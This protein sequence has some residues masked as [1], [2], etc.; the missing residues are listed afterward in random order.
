MYVEHCNSLTD[1]N[2]IISLHKIE[3]IARN[4]EFF[5]TLF[6]FDVSIVTYVELHKSIKGHTGRHFC[7]YI[8]IDI[9]C[10][11][12]MIQAKMDAL[13]LIKKLN[14][15]YGIDPDQLYIY[16]SGGKGFHV[17]IPGQLF[18]P[19]EPS[20]NMG[21]KIK[22]V[23]SALAGEI[24]SVDLKIY[25]NHRI[26]RVENSKHKKGFYKIQLS[27]DELN[28]WTVNKILKVAKK[29]R[30]FFRVYTNQELSINEKLS[31][32]ILST[33]NAEVQVKKDL[34]QDSFF[35][36]P[37]KGN[38]NNQ[39]HKQA[40]SLYMY[41]DLSDTNIFSLVSSINSLSSEPLLEQELKNI[42]HSASS[43]RNVSTNNSP[44]TFSVVKDFTEEFKKSLREESSKISLCFESLDIE[45]KGKLRSKMGVILG[46]GGSKKSIYAQ[47]VTYGNI[48]MGHRVVYS[49]MEMGGIELVKRFY[50]IH[51]QGERDLASEE[52]ENIAKKD[53]NEAEIRIDQNFSEWFSD[54]LIISNGTAMTADNYESLLIDLNNTIG[55]VD[56]LIVDGLSMMGGKGDELEKANRNTQELKELSI[57]FNIFVLVIVHASRG[58][59]LTRRDLSRK[60]RGSEKILD[61]CD[62]AMTMSL[63]KIKNDEYANTCG[64]FHLWNKRGSGN[65]IEKSFQFL[66]QRLLLKELEI[67]VDEL[68][69]KIGAGLEEKR[70]EEFER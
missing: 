5:I 59:D 25:E 15:N 70:R 55:K 20:E 19:L 28:E 44:Q 46:Y 52:L 23:V 37:K 26:I 56:V 69:K 6:P 30:K 53:I 27:F 2:K 22:K 11:D 34:D 18:K 51:K 49:N 47:C 40:C 50:N 9:D 29:P 43:A 60:A 24:E 39:L 3:N 16:F 1:R 33:L 68:Q 31:A 7:P 13:E 35:A 36:P 62:F 63:I 66:P 21:A 17:V 38:R 57:K 32:E 67:S 41:S 45:F 65:R 58:E 14:S 8:L 12:N 48:F 4:H 42:C 61:N 54:K 64:V 10:E